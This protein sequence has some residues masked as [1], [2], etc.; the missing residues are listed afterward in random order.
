MDIIHFDLSGL[1][2]PTECT[3]VDVRRSHMMKKPTLEILQSSD[4]V[5]ATSLELSAPSR[6]DFI[7]GLRLEALRS[8]RESVGPNS[9]ADLRLALAD[10][11]SQLMQR[12]FE[13]L[14]KALIATLLK[15]GARAEYDS[16]KQPV[17]DPDLPDDPT[18]LKDPRVAYKYALK[19]LYRRQFDVAMA[20]RDKQGCWPLLCYDLLDDID[21]KR[22]LMV[23]QAPES[24]Q[25]HPSVDYLNQL[26]LPA[27]QRMR[28]VWE[29]VR[30][31]ALR[32]VVAHRL[33]QA[34]APAKLLRD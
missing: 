33:L 9:V 5:G 25:N 8:H 16:Y 34:Y 11:E 21:G 31:D 15:D 1:V 23:E 32:R 12:Q 26:G 4:P 20:H 13:L 18:T 28:T 2:A 22:S 3:K 10:A 7:E 29:T 27:L 19:R 14:D 17:P 6:F 30:A 24:I